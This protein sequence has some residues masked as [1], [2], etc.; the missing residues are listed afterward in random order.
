MSLPRSSRWVAKIPFIDVSIGINRKR[1][2]P[3]GMLARPKTALQ[4][5]F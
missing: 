1:S 4:A 3:A 5:F 2:L